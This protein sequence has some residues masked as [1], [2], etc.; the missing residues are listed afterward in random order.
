[1]PPETRAAKPDG[2]T[3]Y[4]RPRPGAARMYPETD[5]PPVQI[6]S[7]YLQ[8]L[9]KTL[10]EL[11]EKKMR[12]LTQAYG[13][14][15]KL[16]RQVLDSEFSQLFEE[17]VAESGASPTLV[18]VVLTET[19]KALKREGVKVEKVSDEELLEL[20]CL[21]GR[22]EVTK[23]ALADMISWIARNEGAEVSD[24]I[25]ALGLGILPQTELE[26]IVDTLIKEN[27]RLLAER[28]E[29]AFGTL[30]GLVMKKVRGRANADS[31]TKLVKQKLKE[32]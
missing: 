11:P 25:D 26:K 13:L 6:S 27:R 4:M 22:G 19:L 12:R 8:N 1:V 31:I 3:R 5:V 7:G 9:Q 32:H 23:E 18:A 10:P 20:F 28:G 21:V 17:A 30:M 24:A 2:T 15:E 16:V 14:N 29:K